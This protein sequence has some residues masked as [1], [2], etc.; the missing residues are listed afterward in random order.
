VAAKKQR[1]RFG[2]SNNS[3]SLLVEAAERWHAFQAQSV[4]FARCSQGGIESTDD[5]FDDQQV[6]IAGFDF[7]KRRIKKG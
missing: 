1:N 7:N 5:L 2:D 4:G 6:I 3:N